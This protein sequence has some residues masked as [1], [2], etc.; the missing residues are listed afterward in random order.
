M[1]SEMFKKSV[2]RLSSDRLSISYPV[3]QVQ[4]LATELSSTKYIG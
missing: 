4:Y 1:V 2:K 3:Y